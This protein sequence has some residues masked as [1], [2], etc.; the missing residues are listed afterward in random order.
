LEAGCYTLSISGSWIHAHPVVFSTTNENDV[1]LWSG[2]SPNVVN[3]T[4]SGTIT[5]TVTEADRGTAIY[6]RSVNDDFYGRLWLVASNETASNNDDS[7]AASGGA[8]VIDTTSGTVTSTQ[9]VGA[10][11][12][13]AIGMAAAAAAKINAPF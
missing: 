11:V 8:L 7:G 1:S 6:Y 4:I 9:Q 12:A 5:L 3:G 2:A 10:T 13:T